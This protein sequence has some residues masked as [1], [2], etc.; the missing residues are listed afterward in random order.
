MCA[1]RALCNLARRTAKMSCHSVEFGY[2]RLNASAMS[3]SE[4]PFFFKNSTLRV[5]VVDTTRASLRNVSACAIDASFSAGAAT[6]ALAAAAGG[7][8]TGVVAVAMRACQL[9]W[10]CGAHAS[11]FKKKK[12]VNRLEITGGGLF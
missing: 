5:V 12:K 1:Q 11:P 7:V 3:A 10:L 8:D 6:V 9:V 2:A 4:R